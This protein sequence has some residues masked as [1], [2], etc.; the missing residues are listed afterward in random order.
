MAPVHRPKGVPLPTWVRAGLMKIVF[1]PEC[2][3]DPLVSIQ[4]VLDILGEI[5]QSVV[6]GDP[7]K[8]P[9]ETWAMTAARILENTY[10]ADTTVSIE[11]P[12]S[13]EE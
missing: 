5:P 11:E 4:W 9:N 1:S 6:I 7:V 3:G 8:Y 12:S 10:D 13:V 2:S